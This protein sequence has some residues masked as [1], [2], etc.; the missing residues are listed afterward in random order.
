MSTPI[1]SQQQQA[2]V[3]QPPAVPQGGPPP[4]P[5]TKPILSSPGAYMANFVPPGVPSAPTAGIHGV[6][7][8]HEKPVIAARPIPPPTLPKYTSSFGK[9]DRDRNEFGKIDR[10]EREKVRL[11]H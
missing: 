8:Q 5:A 9:I 11:S 6:N 10:S 4:V 7:K 2:G 3:Q 1:T